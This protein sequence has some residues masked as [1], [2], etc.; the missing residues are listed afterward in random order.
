MV[1]ATA[2]APTATTVP[3]LPPAP[4]VSVTGAPEVIVQE[5]DTLT[6]IAEQHGISVSVLAAW[7]GLND[8]DLI[9]PG[10]RLLLSGES[11]P[12]EEE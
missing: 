2:G 4:P 1:P 8:P 9:F 5:G 3:L 6:S 10:E 12:G 11:E 7:N